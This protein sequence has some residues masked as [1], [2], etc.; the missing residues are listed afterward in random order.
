VV[1]TVSD[2]GIGMD[3]ETQA[4]IFEPFFTTKEMGRGTGLGLATVYGVVKQSEGYIWVYSEPGH[5][6]TFKIHLPRAESAA[7][8]AVAAPRV[9]HAV[10]GNETLL[11]VEDSDSLRELAG[12]ILEGAGYTVLE[13]RNGTEALEVA[14]RHTGTIHAL[15][16]DV[17]MPGMSGRVLAEKL[18]PLR[19][20][21]RVLY[22][23]GYTDDII[24]HHGALEP[25]AVLLQKPF[26]KQSLL[27]KVRAVLDEP[28]GASESGPA[29]KETATGKGAGN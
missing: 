2:T 5:G 11:V 18:I 4:H 19:P 25:G 12:T 26:T 7:A 28:A 10:H 17:I 14:A 13:A 3:S 23:S 21:M 24:V 1:L 20:E 29:A 9:A 15:L 16:S 6:A 27:E 22:V 8:P